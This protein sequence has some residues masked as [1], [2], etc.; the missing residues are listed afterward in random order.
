MTWQAG[1]S[2]E[3]AARDD[4]ATRAAYDDARS[5]AR[6]DDDASSHVI[7]VGSVI[8][9]D[10]SDVQSETDSVV[11]SVMTEMSEWHWEPY[12]GRWI[13]KKGSVPRVVPSTPIV[14]QMH[15]VMKCDL[16]LV[17]QVPYSHETTFVF[18]SCMKSALS[19]DRTVL[20]RGC[21]DGPSSCR[22]RRHVVD[23]DVHHSAL[24]VHGH[25]G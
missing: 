10:R 12:V 11:S 22:R 16:G 1:A 17:C 18:W 13:W 7:D 6:S 15:C 2:R 19:L 9:D 23:I 24:Q 25:L 4:E 14:S 20:W 5:D 21:D 3:L 8:S